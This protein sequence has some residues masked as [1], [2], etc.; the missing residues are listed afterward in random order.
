MS[1]PE[2]LM[3]RDYYSR[4][5][6]FQQ[7][8]IFTMVIER[9]RSENVSEAAAACDRGRSFILSCELVVRETYLEIK[10]LSYWSFFVIDEK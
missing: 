6:L 9:S 2:G 3:V 5:N 4:N 1:I 10:S 8:D 7:R